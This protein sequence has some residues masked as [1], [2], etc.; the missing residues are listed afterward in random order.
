MKA[1]MKILVIINLLFALMLSSGCAT[2]HAVLISANNV[3]TD[4]V[5]YHS[6][7]WYDLFQQYKMLRENGFKDE[8]IHVLYGNGADFNTVYAN[9]NS[10]TQY[11]HAI[12]DM[13][14]NKANVQAV[15]NDIKDNVKSR[16]FLYIW[17]MGHGFGGGADHCNLTM[18]LSHVGEN[19]TDVEFANYISV[20][21]NY[22]KRNVNVMTCHAGGILDNFDT[23]GNKTI[24]LSS[25]TCA[26]SS[27]EASPAAI[28]DGRNRAEFNMTLTEAFREQTACSTAVGSDGDN[29]GYV[30]YTEAHQ[31]N[32]ANMVTSTPQIED[33][34]GLA[35]NTQLKKRKP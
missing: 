11:G 2:K 27:Y 28:C 5:A 8:N 19:V 26:E 13:A 6:V 30:S 23:A 3:T 9:Y 29:N 12:T 34:D 17:W 33:P 7:W 10:T 25:S 31:Y 18:D 15:F 32:Q 21:N 20:V 35:P 24:T 14:A 16:D 22:R 4:D 1:Q